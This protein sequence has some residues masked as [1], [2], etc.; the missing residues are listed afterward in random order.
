WWGQGSFED[1]ALG[2]VL[3]AAAAHGIRVAAHLEPYAGRTPDSVRSDLAYLDGLG[4]REVWIYEA[5]Q[6]PGD[7]LQPVLDAFPGDLLL[8]ETGNIGAVRSGAFAAWAAATHFAGVYTYEA[9]RFEGS[10]LVAFCAGARRL[11]LGCAPAVAPGFSAIR[12]GGSASYARSRDGGATFDHRW[13]GAIGA[14]PSLIVI[15]SYNE[16]HEGTQ[17]EPASPSCLPSG[18]C[19]RTY[20]GD[21]GLS[22]PASQT[23]YLSR[24]AQWAARFR[25]AAP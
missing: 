21:Y 8:A 17:I 24:T 4:L 11:G 3:A 2:G 22:G 15:T 20:D 1:H 5:M 6:L 12:S 16:W 7:Q 13:L 25:A 9:V 19:Y 14:H 18:F 23:S 10:D